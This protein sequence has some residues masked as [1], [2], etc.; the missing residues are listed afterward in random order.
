MPLLG[1]CVQNHARLRSAVSLLEVALGLA[2]MTLVA[3][4]A[5]PTVVGTVRQDAAQRAAR[6][7]QA[8]LDATTAFDVAQP[9]GSQRWPAGV[10]GLEAG[11]VSAIVG[12]EQPVRLQRRALGPECPGPGPRRRRR[13]GGSVGPDDLSTSPSA[14]GISISSAGAGP[15]A[16]SGQLIACQKN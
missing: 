15:N 4:A 12:A 14:T 5:L 8:I 10:A 1:R 6:A 16:P 7:M 3:A 11:R 13:G 9:L 2:V